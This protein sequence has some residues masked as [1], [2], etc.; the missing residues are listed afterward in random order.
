MAEAAPLTDA[1]RA[2]LV[3]VVEGYT[4]AHNH[5]AARREHFD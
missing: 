2:D 3:Q 5:E 4:S 1:E